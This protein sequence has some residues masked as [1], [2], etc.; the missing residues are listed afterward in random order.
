[1]ANL[2]NDEQYAALRP[3]LDFLEPLVSQP[4]YAS[5]KEIDKELR[6][7]FTQ[8]QA[9]LKRGTDHRTHV[10]KMLGGFIQNDWDVTGDVYQASGDVV[11]N[12]I[13]QL[14]VVIQEYSSKLDDIGVRETVAA[15]AVDLKALAAAEQRCRESIKE[16]FAEDARYY[17]P[18]VGETIEPVKG[19]SATQM[20]HSVRR[21]RQRI[22]P[23]F[24]EWVEEN[25]EIRRVRLDNLREAVDKYPCI[26]LLGD[27]GAARPRP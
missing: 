20:P 10:G 19:Q 14:K 5:D 26:I 17:I 23:K 24:C 27:P 11:I 15:E 16:R 4:A 12:K 1:M 3:L 21:R 22:A 13:R 2:R 25:R 6:N 9:E 7:I 18:L 8:L